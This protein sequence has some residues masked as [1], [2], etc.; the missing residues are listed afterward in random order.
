MILPS[1]NAEC[2]KDDSYKPD[3][4]QLDRFSE[5]M[6]M[7]VC[8]FTGSEENRGGPCKAMCGRDTKVVVISISHSIYRTST[9]ISITAMEPHLFHK[10]CFQTPIIICPPET[11]IPNSIPSFS[12]MC[13]FPQVHILLFHS[14][15]RTL[16]S[17]KLIAS[18]HHHPFPNS[19]IL[20]SHPKFTEPCRSS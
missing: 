18:T 3:L 6:S 9:S 19:P 2:Y 15:L 11:K 14:L 5:C 8:Y 1:V 17:R 20:Y 10:T 16:Q 7:H 13:S 12:C 4:E